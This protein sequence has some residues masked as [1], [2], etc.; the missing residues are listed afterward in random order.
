MATCSAS[1][2]GTSLTPVESAVFN[3]LRAV[4]TFQAAGFPNPDR[5]DSVRDL[6]EKLEDSEKV[7]VANPYHCEVYCESCRFQCPL[8]AIS[9]PDRKAFVTCLDEATGTPIW[10]T[11]ASRRLRCSSSC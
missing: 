7:V 4:G 2:T 11:P 10:R 5:A 9:F 6:R 3:D 1:A 8:G